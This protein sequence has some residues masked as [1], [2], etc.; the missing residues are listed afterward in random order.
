MLEQINPSPEHRF[1]CIKVILDVLEMMALIHAQEGRPSPA[2]R[3]A[4]LL[5][6]SATLRRALGA[7]DAILESGVAQYLSVHWIHEDRIWKADL[8]A[9]D[10]KA[11][12]IERAARTIAEKIDVPA[13][14]PRLNE[15][16][17]Y[18]ARRAYNILDEYGAKPTLTV[19]GPYFNL[20]SLL[21]EAVTGKVSVSLEHACRVAWEL[22][23]FESSLR[24]ATNPSH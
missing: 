10:L 7:L 6:V 8:Q 19:D 21:Y 16:K 11:R 23:L 18:A 12:R 24:E 20:A 2:R 15:T 13:G 4:Q 5:S 3:R 9:F 14:K 1:S 17:V 22:F